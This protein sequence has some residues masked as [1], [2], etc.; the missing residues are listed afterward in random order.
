MKKTHLKLQPI[1]IFF[2]LTILLSLNYMYS[3]LDNRNTS[4]SG[5]QSVSETLV[6]GVIYADHNK[7]SLSEYGLGRYYDTSGELRDYDRAFITDD[8]WDNGY[9]RTEA[10]LCISNNEYTQKVA[11][12]GNYVQFSNGIFF[13]ISNIEMSDSQIILS[14]ET[15]QL[16]SY[17]E[18]GNLLDIR[19]LNAQQEP[20][21]KGF[22]SPY[23]SQYGLQG[24]IF[25]FLS[26]YL[27]PDNCVA[28]LNLF[29]CLATATIFVL[30][31]MI[32]FYKYD[33]LMATC[34]LITFLLSPWVVNF[35]KNLYWV[36]FTWFI[37]MLIGLF[38]SWKIN[39]KTCRI[40][41]Y[42]ATFLSI[43]IKCLCGYEYISTIMLG[44]IAFLLVDFILALINKDTK[45][46]KLLFKTIFI[47]GILA[48]L[49]FVIAILIHACLRGNGNIISG[50]KDI[51]TQ[52]VLRRTV[53]GN[54]E[55]WPEVYW[56]SFNASV[57]ETLKKYFSFS[58]EIITG[59]SGSL[60]PML[61]IIPICIFIYNYL[62]YKIVN[63]EL[64]LMYII[65]LLTS[66]SWFTLAKAH[67]YIHTHMNYVLWYFGFVQICF[68]IICKQV[69]NALSNSKRS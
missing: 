3:C 41:S 46:S 5:F 68:Y 35:A 58:T 11:V 33:F 62:N 10:K 29:C 66:I 8:F 55:D 9:S 53:G 22:L 13:K 28:Y 65:F 15:E 18:Y 40:I 2:C 57:G 30:I 63:W 44:M 43:T 50:I 24:K 56:S 67:S 14:L 1:V 39:N 17:N 23:Q 69:L 45:T 16:L 60:F 4:F 59:I 31:V 48:L 61:C 21:E 42:I 25:Y 52:D 19:F 6:S 49:G 7:V 27:N 34:F 38:C 20:L 47:M 12:A 51:Y 54:I 26:Q 64:L 32:L 37:P 36:E